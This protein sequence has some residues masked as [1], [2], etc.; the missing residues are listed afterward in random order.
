MIAFGYF[1]IMIL[2]IVF[3]PCFIDTDS[4]RK[5]ES[6]YLKVAGVSAIAFLTAQHLLLQSRKNRKA[7]KNKIETSESLDTWLPSFIYE[8]P[9][10]LAIVSKDGHIKCW[11]KSF[12]VNI[13][14][15]F[16]DKEISEI[17]IFTNEYAILQLNGNPFTPEEQPVAKAIKTG[18]NISG[19]PMGILTGHNEWSWVEATMH[20][21]KN[22]HGEVLDCICL[23][24]AI[25][26]AHA[27]EADLTVQSFQDRLTGLPNRLFF[28][29]LLSQAISRMQKHDN[30][31]GVLYIDLNRFKI[32]N[33]TLN[34]EMGDK[35]LIQVAKRLKNA[36]R[37]GDTIARLFG[38]EFGVLFEDV[39][40]LSEV[41]LVTD[42]IRNVFEDPFILNNEE[43]YMSCSMGL[44]ISNNS[45][46]TPDE[47]IRD[48]EVAMHRAK[49]EESETIEIYDQSM[50]EQARSRLKMESEIRHALQK[51]EFVVYYQ[52]LVNLST[53]KIIGWEA[54]VRWQ[55]P[56]RGLVPPIQF[57][58]IAEETNLIIPIGT[59]VLEEA[60]RQAQDWR[61]RF[62]SYSE[63]I[64]N[65]NLSMHQFQQP[66][67]SEIIIET[68]EKQRFEPSLL[69]LEI[70]ESTSMKDAATSI[71]VMANLRALKIHFAIDDFGTG[72]SSLSYLKR[73]P[74]DTLKIDKSF[75]DGLGLDNESTAIVQAIISMATALNIRVTAEGIENAEQLSILRAMNCDIGQ[76]Y[77]FSRPLPPKDAEKL[78][79]QDFTW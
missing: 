66:N 42:W 32:I 46:L 36:I 52:P 5:N 28:T 44:T 48:S 23:F 67:L 3:L 71:A 47:L 78:M 74:V 72:Y 54:L 2:W 8:L 65:V 1:V 35:I 7:A 57:I 61:M 15:N 76:G 24:E 4:H 55:H 11:S 63:S 29:E 62:P 10:N 75:V 56:E 16:S 6:K 40:D 26:D 12:Y 51:N 33:D 19:V 13:I 70:T 41:I 30:R 53:G 77:H 27:T 22:A 49:A 73:M 20:V 31:I 45:S 43:Y 14:S 34:Y 50:N 17:N 59:Q 60:C 25:S 38:D 39:S 58:E 69:K 79:E 68:L 18:E 37:H 9:I 64:M 21:R